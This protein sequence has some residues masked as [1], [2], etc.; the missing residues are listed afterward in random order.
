MVTEILDPSNGCHEID[1][2]ITLDSS[3]ELPATIIEV[4][5]SVFVP[6]KGSGHCNNTS[7]RY[8]I[9]IIINNPN[10]YSK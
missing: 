3:C 7:S 2:D 5:P 6:S 4:E 1:P 8:R 9:W 10:F